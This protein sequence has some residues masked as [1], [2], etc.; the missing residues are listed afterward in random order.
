MKN[1]TLSF[2]LLLVC[3]STLYSQDN[4]ILRNGQEIKA[5]VEEVGVTEIK[6]KKVDNLT[7][8]TYVISKSE[9]FLIQYPNGTKDVLNEPASTATEKADNYTAPE[10]TPP[11]TDNY[12]KYHRLAVKKIVSGAVVTALGVPVL[13]TGLVLTGVGVGN[14]NSN[15]P[16]SGFNPFAGIALASGLVATAGGIAMLIV[17]PINLSKGVKYH[18]L[19]KNAQQPTLGFVPIQNPALDQLCQTM[20][21]QKLA[22][23]TITF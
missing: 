9:V 8:P 11:A 15:D 7:G 22:T 5:K 21:Q 13:T 10:T 2:C 23:V 20:N 19:A 14:L 1:I 18:R 12:R 6:Y 16:Y 3:A 17:G 4:I